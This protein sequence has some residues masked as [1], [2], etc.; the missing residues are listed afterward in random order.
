MDKTKAVLEEIN[1]KAAN[2]SNAYELIMNLMNDASLKLQAYRGIDRLL[3]SEA[4]G[5]P[6][7]FSQ[8]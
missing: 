7:D 1:L 6:E 2:A 3:T 5:S 8:L 4:A